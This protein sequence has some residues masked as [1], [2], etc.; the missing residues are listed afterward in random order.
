MDN[1]YDKQQLASVERVKLATDIILPKVTT[2]PLTLKYLELGNEY[3]TPFTEY[4]DMEGKFYITIMTPL[5]DKSQ[6]NK[7][8]QVAPSVRGHKGNLGTN[9]YSSS[10]YITL[11]IPK[12]ILLNFKDKVPKGTEFIVASVGN[13]VDLDDLRIIGIYSIITNGGK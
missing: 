6:A 12:Y 7:K 8:S 4:T 1:Y 13:T 11:T 2:E 3:K 5:V 9:N 10:N